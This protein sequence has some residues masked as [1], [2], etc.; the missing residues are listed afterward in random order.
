MV[1]LYANKHVS[2]TVND[3]CT[4]YRKMQHPQST[5]ECITIYIANAGIRLLRVNAGG[6]AI[7]LDLCINR[8]R[9]ESFHR[10]HPQGQAEDKRWPSNF[11]LQWQCLFGGEALL[12]RLSCSLV[13]TDTTLLGALWQCSEQPGRHRATFAGSSTSRGLCLA[14]AGESSDGSE[15]PLAPT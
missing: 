8:F 15:Y 4:Y 3:H 1:H 5:S 6:A 12:A 9:I 10:R 7:R 13:N 14:K 2:L 11:S